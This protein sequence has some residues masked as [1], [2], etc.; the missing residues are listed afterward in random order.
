MN[1]SK[2]NQE[3]KVGADG[4]TVV[5]LHKYLAKSNYVLKIHTEI[6]WEVYCTKPYDPD[7]SVAFRGRFL[8]ASSYSELLNNLALPPYFAQFDIYHG[9]CI[10][11]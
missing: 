2:L 8:A 4:H 11:G 3:P 10:P 9:A 1:I 6:P 5:V 7:L